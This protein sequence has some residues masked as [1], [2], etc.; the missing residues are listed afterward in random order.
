MDYLTKNVIGS[1]IIL[2][3]ALIGYFYT[4]KTRSAFGYKSPMSLKNEKTWKYANN[5][6]SKL[7][8]VVAI[9]FIFLGFLLYKICDSD[10]N[11]YKYSFLF[12]TI[13]SVL[14]I[15][16]TEIILNIK[17]DKNGNDKSI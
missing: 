5:L 16:I 1:I 8:L 12:L 7:F 6:A 9:L 2:I 17:Y 15:P 11:A 3:L 4:P 13:S 10:Y 14:I